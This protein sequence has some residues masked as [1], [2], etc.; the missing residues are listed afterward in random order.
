M[1]E[2]ALKQ[3]VVEEEVEEGE[4]VE[5]E[6]TVEDTNELEAVEES[7]EDTKSKNNEEELQDYSDK[8]QKRINNLTRK[9]KKLKE[10][11]IQ[12][13]VMLNL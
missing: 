6:E 10:V 13:I 2:E 3:E 11:K 12:H 4:I 7:V 9:L 1:S 5:L 8:V